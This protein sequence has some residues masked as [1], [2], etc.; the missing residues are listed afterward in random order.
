MKGR[1]WVNTYILVYIVDMVYIRLKDLWQL[2]I[3]PAAAFVFRWPG[4]QVQ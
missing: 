2:Q 1:R 4:H 3:P